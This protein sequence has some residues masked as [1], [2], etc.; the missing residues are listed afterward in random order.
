[1]RCCGASLMSPLPRRG[2][3]PPSFVL[4]RSSSAYGSQRAL[5]V[6]LGTT[7]ARRPRWPGW[8][9]FPSTRPC[10]QR[11]RGGHIRGLARRAR[12]L[13]GHD[14]RMRRLGSP[15]ADE[16]TAVGLGNLEPRARC[17]SR[18]TRPRSADLAIGQFIVRS[19]RATV[20]RCQ[21]LSLRS[22]SCRPH[23][24]RVAV[25]PRSPS[26]PSPPLVDAR[27][28]LRAQGHRVTSPPDSS[29]ERVIGQT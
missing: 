12:S 21:A 18:G 4:S 14:A 11:P 13:V 1:M 19:G 20:S 26:M 23:R 10:G 15:G 5:H 6:G 9:L 29:M 22:T 27:A 17:L 28:L 7:R 24:G 8:A 16:L 25:R 3:D 2:C